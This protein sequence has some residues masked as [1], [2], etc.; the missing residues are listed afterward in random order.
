MNDHDKDL[1]LNRVS[2]MDPDGHVFHQWALTDMLAAEIAHKAA[3]L[4]ME[5]IQVVDVYIPWTAAP[6]L[7]HWLNHHT[8]NPYTIEDTMADDAL[9][10]AQRV[11]ARQKGKDEEAKAAGFAVQP[12]ESTAAAAYGLN[13]ASALDVQVGGDHYKN[14]KI[15]PVQY[16]HAN[17]IPFI[18]GCVIK[19]VSRWRSK[20]GIKDLEKARHFIDILID[21]ERNNGTTV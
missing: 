14:Q 3:L 9:A 15:Q 6:D 20:G 10:A 1:S 7:A 18:E 8:N 5:A 17:N 2:F 11:L 4:G 21:L 16:I 13:T 19:Y 12:D